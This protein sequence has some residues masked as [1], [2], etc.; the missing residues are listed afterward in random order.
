VAVQSSDVYNG[1]CERNK[2]E[3]LMASERKPQAALLILA[4]IGAGVLAGAIVGIVL[5]KRKRDTVKISESV[6]DLR[7]K[8]ERAER[9][10]AANHR[11][12]RSQQLALRRDGLGDVNGTF[13]DSLDRRPWQEREK[14][15]PRQ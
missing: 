12:R 13:R 1:V 15:E 5:A 4:G 9:D 6:D 7:D 11:R 14:T 3:P 10:D 2:V 8:A